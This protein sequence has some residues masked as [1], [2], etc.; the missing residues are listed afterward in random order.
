MA[1]HSF[2]ASDASRLLKAAI[3]GGLPL[4]RLRIIHD[5]DGRKISI[6]VQRDESGGPTSKG[7]ELDH[8]MASRAD[9]SKGS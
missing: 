8:W 7:N 3:A 1:R 9:Q 6:E 4:D 2:K 5:I